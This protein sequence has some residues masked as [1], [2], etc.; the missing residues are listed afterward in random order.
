MSIWPYMPTKKA[1]CSNTAACSADR[2]GP[3][4]SAPAPQP[5]SGTEP[6][7]VLAPGQRTEA[8]GGSKLTLAEEGVLGQVPQGCL[9]HLKV[10]AAQTVHERGQEVGCDAE[11]ATSSG[12]PRPST[13]TLSQDSQG[14]KAPPRPSPGDTSSPRVALDGAQGQAE[15]QA[16]AGL[17]G[18]AHEPLQAGLRENA[19][20]RGHLP[21]G[22][23]PQRVWPGTPLP[24][25]CSA[26][27]LGWMARHPAP[28]GRRW[29]WRCLPP[30]PPGARGRSAPRRSPGS[31]VSAETSHPRHSGPP[32]DLSR[33]EGVCDGAVSPP[34]PATWRQGAESGAG[35]LPSPHRM[36]RDLGLAEAPGSQV[37]H[38]CS[39]QGAQA[40]WDPPCHLSARSGQGAPRTS[41]C[42]AWG[43]SAFPTPLGWR[44]WF[45]IDPEVRAPP[46]PSVRSAGP[47]IC[48]CTTSLGVCPWPPQSCCSH[49]ALPSPPPGATWAQLPRK[50]PGAAGQLLARPPFLGVHGDSRGFPKN[51]GQHSSPHPPPWSPASS[52][53]PLSMAP[54]PL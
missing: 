33:A 3:V 43:S 11:K 40:S 26:S 21:L 46:R 53:K 44:L 10:P 22:P 27:V 18:R 9:H 38:G 52:S 39:E 17:L 6:L 4:S 8:P 24:Q 45:G 16:A 25:P 42:Q 23:P 50:G 5:L 15:G 34:I 1:R 19:C 13:P 36:G 51:T 41:G 30:Q 14:P 47:G 12:E 48:V 20:Q 32:A 29:G 31:P 49:T 7:P 35:P 28:A 2:G 54:P 37:Q